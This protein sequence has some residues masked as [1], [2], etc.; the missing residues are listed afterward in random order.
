[1]LGKDNKKHTSWAAVAVVI[2]MMAFFSGCASATGEKGVANKWRDLN[3]PA[4]EAGKTTDQDVTS[5]LGPPSQIIA[6]QD[7][8]VY[9]YMQERSDRK[10]YVFILWNYTKQITRYDRAVFFFDKKGVLEKFS[11]SL[12]SFPYNETP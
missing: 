4:W 2:G 11:Y 10:A 8:V 1:M 6:L 5:L 7:Q 3:L 9:Y 12:E